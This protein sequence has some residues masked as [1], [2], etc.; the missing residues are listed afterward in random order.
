LNNK[1]VNQG[2]LC[3]PQ[4]MKEIMRYIKKQSTYM[5]IIADRRMRNANESKPVTERRNRVGNIQKML[6][7][8]LDFAG[9]KDGDTRH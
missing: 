6:R 9:V 5:R 3:L 2:V 1:F 4:D 7:A 8:Y